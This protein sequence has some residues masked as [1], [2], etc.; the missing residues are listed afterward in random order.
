MV[1]FFRL[2]V[3]AFLPLA[4]LTTLNEIYTS[5]DLCIIFRLNT[6]LH[7][8]EENAPKVEINLYILCRKLN[9]ENVLV[10]NIP[11][12]ITMIIKLH[13]FFFSAFTAHTS[14][15]FS[16]KVWLPLF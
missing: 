8:L 16:A 10:T 14:L 5:F 11:Q 4:F 2:L 6:Q 9:I 12:Y 13:I 15:V 1:V 7:F 3:F